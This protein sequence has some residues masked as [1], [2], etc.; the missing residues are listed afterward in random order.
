MPLGSTLRARSNSAP[1]PCVRAL[2]SVTMAEFVGAVVLI[3]P[4]LANGRAS[5][6][7]LASPRVGALWS[8]TFSS[9]EPYVNAKPRGR[10]FFNNPGPTNIPDRVLRAMDRPVLD[11]LSEEFLAIDHACHAGVERVTKTDQNHSM[12]NEDRH[13]AWEAAL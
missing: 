3:C 2:Y 4:R 9:A 12:Y 7:S 6:A 11:F 13:G 1:G 5:Q 10:Q 8:A